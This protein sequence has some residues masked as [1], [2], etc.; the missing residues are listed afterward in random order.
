MN[1][2]ESKRDGRM[3][4]PAIKVP[5]R[6]CEF[7]SCASACSDASPIDSLDIPPEYGF[8][9]TGASW[10]HA[11]ENR[12]ENV[13]DVSR[14]SWRVFS[15]RIPESLKTSRALPLFTQCYNAKNALMR[16]ALYR[17]E[18]RR[19]E[20]EEEDYI[21]HTILL[22]YFYSF[23]FNLL[24]ALSFPRPEFRTHKLYYLCAKFYCNSNICNKTV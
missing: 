8:S 2:T 1:L 15:R 18:K 19:K 17:E 23:L 12:V 3:I 22:Y 20:E 9:R 10:R 13:H 5:V 6:Y 4:A 7:S 16:G 21:L 14:A 11:K 24:F